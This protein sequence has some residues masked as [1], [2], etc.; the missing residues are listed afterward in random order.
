MMPA[1]EKVV[2]EYTKGRMY[3]TT[4]YGTIETIRSREYPSGWLWCD[5]GDGREVMEQPGKW[6][7]KMEKT[8]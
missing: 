7:M 3:E 8:E 4:R 1:S 2:V 5:L 6:K